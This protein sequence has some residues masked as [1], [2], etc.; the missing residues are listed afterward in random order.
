[1]EQLLPDVLKAG[2]ARM[3]CV[4]GQL[5]MSR[6]TL[7]RRLR[8]EGVTF[9]EVVNDVRYRLARSLLRD[10]ALSVSQVASLLGFSEAT[11]FTRAFRRWSGETPAAYARRGR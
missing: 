6:Q 5:A 7:L 11:A 2:N 10:P 8:S 3:A 9:E 4:A 1:V